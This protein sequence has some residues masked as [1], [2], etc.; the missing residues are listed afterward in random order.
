MASFTTSRK[1]AWAEVSSS[2]AVGTARNSKTG[3]P[4]VDAKWQRV[5]GQLARAYIADPDCF[6]Y[7]MYLA[8]NRQYGA[9]LELKDLLTTLVQ[10]AEG[11]LYKSTGVSTMPEAPSYLS[12]STSVESIAESANVLAAR[13]KTA[14]ASSKVGRRLTEKGDEA[15]ALYLNNTTTFVQKY[16]SFQTALSTMADAAPDFEP[17]RQLAL[18]DVQTSASAATE[19]L[20]STRSAAAFAVQN[21]AASA[22]LKTVNRVPDV[23]VRL[24]YEQVFFPSGV[25][26]SV[27]GTT[28][29]FSTQSPAYCYVR[30]GDSFIWAGGETT[31]AS[32][33]DSTVTLSASVGAP[34]SYKVVPGPYAATKSLQDA[35]AAF[36]T[37]H[38]VAD[39]RFLSQVQDL[40]GGQG[41]KDVISMLAG[42]QNSLTGLS[43]D[44][45]DTLERLG[46]PE[47]VA[48]T[49]ISSTLYA[50]TP[51][52]PQGTKETTKASLSTLQREGFQLAAQRFLSG[53]L[54]FLSETVDQQHLSGLFDSVAGG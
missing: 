36:L 54:T 24:S 7:Q 33:G 44:V 25:N 15:L 18:V 5:R 50:Y 2:G 47:P 21:A 39:K 1:T 32:V 34:S 9:A 42:I 11:S 6:F 13:A 28:I 45:A 40:P 20:Y 46:L 38:A 41:T 31:V 26:V 29:T 35:C 14:A 12:G 27:N 17:L 52:V 19:A 3:T 10:Y 43:T 37:A 23:S 16:F 30:A 8:S 22:A 48:E 53:D 4:P 49:P 51:Q